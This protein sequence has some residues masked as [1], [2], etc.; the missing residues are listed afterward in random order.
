M[1]MTNE[2]IQALEAS[3]LAATTGD[4]TADDNF[5]FTVQCYRTGTN[6][7][8]AT[9]NGPNA[10][11]DMRFIAQ[12]SPQNILRVLAEREADKALIA[13]SVVLF[14]TLRQ[15]IAELEQRHCGGALME[16]EKHH[17]GVVNKLLERIA[18]LEARTV[19]VKLPRDI[20][21]VTNKYFEEG[22]DAVLEAIESQLAAAGIT[23]DVG[24]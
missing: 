13:E 20:T 1:S 5:G 18:E 15:R 7:L 3:A 19:T 10:E 11:N 2:Q 8:L 17:V 21:H 4:W 9:V 6:R 14:E 16:R 24:E 23:L 12:A 22:R